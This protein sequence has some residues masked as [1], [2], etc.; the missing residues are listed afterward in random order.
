MTPLLAPGRCLLDQLPGQAAKQTVGTDRV[1]DDGIARIE[2]STRFAKPGDSTVRAI[3]TNDK[4]SGVAWR[5]EVRVYAADPPS[6]TARP[7]RGD[8][9]GP[10]AVD[11]SPRR[12]AAVP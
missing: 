10:R 2:S 5:F 3:Y 11:V 9:A 4:G 7:R 8:P 1:N 12:G 6:S